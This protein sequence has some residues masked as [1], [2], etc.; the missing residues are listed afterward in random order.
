[1]IKMMASQQPPGAA[2]YLLNRPAGSVKKTVS[3]VKSAC[4][5]GVGCDRTPGLARRAQQLLFGASIVD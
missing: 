1:M 4:S 3:G 5:C 2:L